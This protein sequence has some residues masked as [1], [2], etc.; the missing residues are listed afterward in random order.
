MFEGTDDAKRGKL[1][2][3]IYDTTPTSADAPDELPFVTIDTAMPMFHTLYVSDADGKGKPE[4]VREAEFHIKIGGAATGSIEDYRYLGRD[5]EPPYTKE[6]TNPADAGKQAHYMI[7][8][9]NAKDERGPFQLISAT[10]TSLLQ[11][12]NS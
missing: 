5:T 10:I 4:G 6:F 7:C 2:V 12:D 11:T 8:W 9:L 1:G 3:P